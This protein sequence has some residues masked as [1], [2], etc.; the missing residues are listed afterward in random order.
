MRYNG[1][2]ADADD[3]RAAV[4]RDLVYR[5][6][7]TLLPYA[8]Y[9]Q[10]ERFIDNLGIVPP[11]DELRARRVK[12][13]ALFFFMDLRVTPDLNETAETAFSETEIIAAL[14]RIYGE[15]RLLLIP[16][17]YR[18]RVQRLHL[19]IPNRCAV[20][21]Y[22]EQSRFTGLLFQPLDRP[23][24]TFTLSSRRFGGPKAAP[25]P[26]HLRRLLDNTTT[27]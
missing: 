5:D 4:I 1:A 21:A 22:R 7:N 14:N 16:G 15:K 17:F 3:I 25:M 12:S 20:F 13:A 23:G 24:R 6:L 26:T 8:S 19:A 10:A 11:G 9:D 2:D 18:D 27:K